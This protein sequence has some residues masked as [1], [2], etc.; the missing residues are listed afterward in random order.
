MCT[1]EVRRNTVGDKKTL[2]SLI[3]SW[4]SSYEEEP[5]RLSLKRTT[6]KHMHLFLHYDAVGPSWTTDSGSGQNGIL[7]HCDKLT[8][9]V[10]YVC[11]GGRF[12]F[13]FS[14]SRRRGG[15]H[16]L[17]SKRS[18]IHVPMTVE[19]GEERSTRNRT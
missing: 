4:P 9:L 12:C 13:G 2:Q 6:S 10:Q 18:R 19:E 3:Q 14:I 11:I 1:T 15:I 16:P 8:C 7:P 17:R 5:H